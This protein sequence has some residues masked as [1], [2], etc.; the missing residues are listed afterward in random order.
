MVNEIKRHQLAAVIVL[1]TIT[2]AVV[3]ALV[4]YRYSSA[5]SAAISSVAVLPFTN[6]SGD[7]NMIIFRMA[8]V[9][10]SLTISRNYLL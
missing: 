8:S 2:L 7:P 9:K 5:R 10:V 6:Q 1:A 4:Y 3:A